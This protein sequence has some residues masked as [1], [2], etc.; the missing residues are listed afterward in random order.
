MT[1]ENTS[2][3]SLCSAHIST[4]QQEADSVYLALLQYSASCDCPSPGT[5]MQEAAASIKLTPHCHPVQL[6]PTACAQQSR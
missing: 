3:R 6:W 4:K 2:H 5:L 1:A